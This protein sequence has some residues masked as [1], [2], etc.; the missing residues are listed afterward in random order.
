MLGQSHRRR[1]KAGVGSCPRRSAVGA[2]PPNGNRAHAEGAIS[3]LGDSQS[4]VEISFCKLY[5]PEARSLGGGDEDDQLFVDWRKELEAH[6]PGAGDCLDH[7]YLTMPEGKLPRDMTKDEIQHNWQD[8]KQ[9]DTKEI[10]GLYDLGCSPRHPR[11]KS[12]NIIDARLVITGKMIEDNVGAKCRLTVR[13]FMDRFQDL[14]TYV[15]TISRSGQRMVNAVA[16][17]H[18]DFILSSFDVSQAFAKRFNV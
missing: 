6:A 17:G 12:H 15:G 13:G 3:A 9:A 2:S 8:V 16:E 7:D 5:E 10:K 1:V 4:S 14:D 18:E 11:H